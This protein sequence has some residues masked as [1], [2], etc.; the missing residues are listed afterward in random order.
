MKTLMLGWGN[1]D[2]EDDGVA[3]NVLAETARLAGGTPPATY[4]EPFVNEGELD[5]LFVLQLTP[6][7]AADIVAYDRLILVDAHTGDKQERV[8]FQKIEPMYQRSP[9]TH[10]LTAETLTALAAQLYQK[11]IPAVLISVL[12]RSFNF[13]QGLSPETAED[14]PAAAKMALEW[15]RE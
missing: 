8:S 10:H 5:F 11:K 12:G 3:W 9:F 4:E 1:P 7:L 15:L 2:R 6:E 13:R 14:V